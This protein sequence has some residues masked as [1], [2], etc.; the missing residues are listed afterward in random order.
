[1]TYTI[2]L[3]WLSLLSEVLLSLIFDNGC[4]LEVFCEEGDV[5]LLDFSSLE[6]MVLLSLLKLTEM[7]DLLTETFTE[8]LS[9]AT[10]IFCRKHIEKAYI[11][12]V[13]V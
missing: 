4:S 13:K 2:Q 9:L 12:N 7:P 1:M 6:D 11:I 10:A 3:S 8:T 5:W